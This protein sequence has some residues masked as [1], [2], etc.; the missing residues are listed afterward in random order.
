M[1]LLVALRDSKTGT[2][3]GPM[4][5]ATPGEAERKYQEILEGPGTLVQ[6][7]P[8]DFPLYHVGNYDEFT[9]ELIPLCDDAGNKQLPRL[10]LEAGQFLTKEV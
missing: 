2:F 6:K 3:L 8:R 5:A 4:V 7:F 9:G 1:K 10:L